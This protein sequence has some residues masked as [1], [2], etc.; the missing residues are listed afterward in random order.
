VR[1]CHS[2]PTADM[3]RAPAAPHPSNCHLH[4]S[5]CLFI[6]LCVERREPQSS[7]EREV[8]RR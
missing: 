4:L 7:R 1:L 8:A 5:E 2:P 6:S 3:M